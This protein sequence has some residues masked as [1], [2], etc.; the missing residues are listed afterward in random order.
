M[1]TW[2][3][4]VST[5][6]PGDE[7]VPGLGLYLPPPPHEMNGYLPKESIYTS[8]GDEWVLG[9]RQYLPTGDEWVPGLGQYLPPPPGDEWVP[10]L[11]QYLP[12]RR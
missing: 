12:L 6:P 3:T 4:T 5:P 11:G 9:L 10:G 1:G 8:I 2:P 7:W